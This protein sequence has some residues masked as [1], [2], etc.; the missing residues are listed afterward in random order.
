MCPEGWCFGHDST[1]EAQGVEGNRGECTSPELVRQP[2]YTEVVSASTACARTQPVP[3]R[4]H[5][6]YPENP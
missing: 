1:L 6:H 2:S 4:M 5:G 3:L